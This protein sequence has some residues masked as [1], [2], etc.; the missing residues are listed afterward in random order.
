MPLKVSAICVCSSCRK[1]TVVI[2][3]TA[4]PGRKVHPQT[5]KEHMFRG[6]RKKNQP[7]SDEDRDTDTGDKQ[8]GEF[9]FN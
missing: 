9:P 6:R 2:D 5:H 8:P 1:H 3:G 7:T 4:Q